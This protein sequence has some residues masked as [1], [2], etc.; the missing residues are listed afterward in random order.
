MA[1][2][3]VRN[4][5][6]GF[7]LSMKMEYFITDH[8]GNTRVSFEDNG[9]GV[10]V[11]KQ[12]NSYYAFG[13]QMAGSYTPGSNPNKKLYNAGSEWQ[14]DIEGLADYYS[15]F[16]REYDPIIG[17]FNGVD[18]LAEMTDEISVYAYADN[19]PVM[20]NDPLGAAANKDWHQGD[21]G[22]LPNLDDLNDLFES[23][24]NNDLQNAYLLWHEAQYGGRG[25]SLGFDGG[26][27][28]GD[29]ESNPT[30]NYKTLRGVTVKAK[31]S[32]KRKA[33][34]LE[35]MKRDNIPWEI[36]VHDFDKEG[37]EPEYNP[38]FE[39]S[40]QRN[41]KRFNSAS[42]SI[43]RELRRISNNILLTTLKGTAIVQGS[44]LIILTGAEI[45]GPALGLVTEKSIELD[46]LLTRTTNIVIRDFL[47]SIRYQFRNVL[48]IDNLIR[49]EKLAEKYY[50]YKKIFKSL[51]DLKKLYET[52]NKL[53]F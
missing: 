37:N 34:I 7:G 4:E 49:L 16:F 35:R 24:S 21:Y 19:N 44:A 45:W 13:M 50:D 42:G 40:T 25:W 27:G 46:F 41:I 12:E 2:G 39:A 6:G 36:A 52:F 8:Q 48:A 32:P 15:T 38:E 9:S 31:Y 14:D 29:T 47:L 23:I 20:M 5:G 43:E 30:P 28:D 18:P 11:L 53:Q 10:A 26:D 1:E 33:A 22:W 51:Q 17:R 3:R